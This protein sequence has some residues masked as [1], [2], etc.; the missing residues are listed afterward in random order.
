MF[1]G[2]SLRDQPPTAS[3]R[4]NLRRHTAIAAP[5]ASDDPHPNDVD[6]AP[7]VRPTPPHVPRFL[8]RL[9]SLTAPTT[10]M[11]RREP[12]NTPSG[13]AVPTLPRQLRGFDHAD[14]AV[15]RPTRPSGAAIPNCLGSFMEPT[16]RMLRCEPANSAVK[17]PP[18]RRHRGTGQPCRR[19]N[20]IAGQPDASPDRRRRSARWKPHQWPRQLGCSPRISGVVRAVRQPR[21]M[22]D[23]QRIARD[24]PN[25]P[26]QAARL[27]PLGRRRRDD[28]AHLMQATRLVSSTRAARRAD[29]TGLALPPRGDHALL[30][31]PARLTQR[32]LDRLSRRAHLVRYD[33]KSIACSFQ[34]PFQVS[35]HVTTISRCVGHRTTI[36]P[37]AVDSIHHARPSAPSTSAASG[38]P[39]GDTNVPS[40]AWLDAASYTLHAA[41]SAA[42]FA[43]W[44]GRSSSIAH[45]ETERFENGNTTISRCVGHR[46]TIVPSAVDSIH[47]GWS[48]SGSRSAAPGQPRGDTNASSATLT[49][50]ALQAATSAARRP[51]RE[52][53][54][55]FLARRNLE[56]ARFENGNARGS[57]PLF[58]GAFHRY[59]RPLPRQN[60]APT[61]SS[62]RHW[63]LVPA[64]RSLADRG[65]IV[66]ISAVSCRLITPVS[67][68]KQSPTAG[69]VGASTVPP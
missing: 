64:T 28:R 54:R 51:A 42:Q 47:Q 61:A 39:R 55:L 57:P 20:A 50:Y 38:H 59:D 43:S 26:A 52:L 62:A 49:S 30:A 69:R 45:V 40:A 18:P 15:I 13:A 67:V 11:L 34:A 44:V 21:Q 2:G 27:V 35:V 23:R 9:G 24:P 31:R 12:A 19:G 56:T 3:R 32:S 16:T 60:R 7:R 10:P 36:V 1:R 66:R 33:A 6:A 63:Q 41:I 65:L 14:A 25:A 29:G 53:G 5:V 8:H 37:G 68:S 58:P 22:V 48:S 17:P 46:T 4:R